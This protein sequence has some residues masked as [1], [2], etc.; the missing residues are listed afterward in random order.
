VLR[1]LQVVGIVRDLRQ[2]PARVR[3]PRPPPARPSDHM[4][5]REP[6]AV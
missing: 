6:V 3:D 4:E 2:P 5:E 1:L